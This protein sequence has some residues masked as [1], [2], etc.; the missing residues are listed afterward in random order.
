MSLLELLWRNL[1][2]RK[3]LSLL[4]VA[5]VAVTV[6]LLVVLL[7]CSRG[8]ETGAA[9]GYGPF[10][11]TIGAKGSASQLALN[12]YYHVGAPTGNVPYAVFEA[13]SREPEAERA[14]ALTTGDS[15]NGFPIV[16]IAPGYFV[17][18]YSDRQLA[19]G[20]L[21]GATGEVV[22]GAYAAKE[23]HAKLGDTFHGAHGLVA[24]AADEDGDEEEHRR[25]AYTVVGIL[26]ALHTADDRAVFTTTDYAWQVHHNEHGGEHEVTAILLKPKSLAG[27]QS[28]K[29]KYQNVSNVQA[30]FTSKAVADVVNVVDT[31]TGAVKIVTALCVLLAAVTVLLSLT[32]AVNERKRDV[33]L[34]RLLGKPRGYIW[35]TLIGEGLLL[36][37]LGTLLGLLAGHAAGFAGQD[38][39][40]AYTGLQIAP[41]R[42][43]PGEAL[44][45][46]EACLVGFAAS[47][48]P[49]LQAY[50]MDPLQMFRG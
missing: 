4:A 39:I 48:G 5:A 50:R 21:Y 13:V 20:R 3:L 1:L 23:L 6:A 11:L 19:A 35:L 16:G 26:P 44:L 15:Y 40:F 12:T 10:E 14:F 45:A 42:L 36:T 22:L 43:L 9:S 17:T 30:I 8:L 2:H 28:L 7:L 32:Q 29:T 27:A 34:L 46:A 37:V 31:G 49:A 24:G 47:V 25:F 38:A 33:A 18:R 41:G